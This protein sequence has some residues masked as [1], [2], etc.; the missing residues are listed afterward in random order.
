MV[1]S[2][3][4]IVSS[5]QWGFQ[6]SDVNDSSSEGPSSLTQSEIDTHGV[7]W[8]DNGSN[9]TDVNYPDIG[10]PSSLSSSHQLSLSLSPPPE[11]GKEF[12]QPWNSARL[13]APET[14]TREEV[15][16]QKTKDVNMLKCSS[17]VFTDPWKKGT[18][19]NGLSYCD[20]I[21]VPIP[22]DNTDT[23]KKRPY[24]QL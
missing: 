8:S 3:I 1:L 13:R 16:Q 6:W 20:C 4:L 21:W 23:K 11:Q 10:S 17:W 15:K 5:E 2:C 22:K 9:Q 24:Q 12:S 18:M 14:I 19:Q 7:G